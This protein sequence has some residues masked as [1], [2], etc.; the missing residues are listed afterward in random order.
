[1]GR[2]CSLLHFLRAPSLFELSAAADVASADDPLEHQLGLEAIE[3]FLSAIRRFSTAVPLL[4]LT[5]LV[6]ADPAYKPE[7]P[8]GGEEWLVV[9]RRYWQ[10]R[11]QRAVEARSVDRARQNALARAAAVLGVASIEGGTQSSKAVAREYLRSSYASSRRALQ[12]LI[13]SG[14]FY[15][16]TSR[17][18]LTSASLYLDGVAEG[19]EMTADTVAGKLMDLARV[20]QAVLREGAEE[21]LD[22][23]SNLSI[24]GGREGDDLRDEW[25]LIAAEVTSIAGLIREL[26]ALERRSEDGEHP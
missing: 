4:S 8:G 22:S 9:Y 5:R 2:L 14:D 13:L 1:M 16:T 25:A 7:P 10:E 23:I 24:I 20:L 12:I 18:I 3:G 11:L 15:Q 17:E 6:S 26:R 19:A 21:Q